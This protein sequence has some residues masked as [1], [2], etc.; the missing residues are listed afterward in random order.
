MP[1]PNDPVAILD[2]AAEKLGLVASTGPR[3]EIRRGA[4]GLVGGIG[5][6]RAESDPIGFRLVV[7]SRSAGSFVIRPAVRW[8]SHLAASR[9]RTGAVTFD[10]VLSCHGAPLTIHSITGPRERDVL[11]GI[12]MMHAFAAVSIEPA[13]LVLDTSSLDLDAETLVDLFSKLR[14]L[15]ALV[16]RTSAPVEQRLLAKV[17]D[18]GAPRARAAAAELLFD[19]LVPGS[20]RECDACLAMAT[21]EALLP[22]VRVDAMIRLRRH[23]PELVL[24]PMRMLLDS[25]APE[26]VENAIRFLGEV[27][28]DD[29]V[30]AI[31][32]HVG[33]PEGSVRRAVAW[34]LG[35]LG[36]DEAER[37]LVVLVESDDAASRAAME[38]LVFVGGFRALAALRPRVR[39]LLRAAGD[40]RVAR[41]AIAAIEARVGA[42]EPGRLAIAEAS[43]ELSVS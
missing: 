20:S 35:R 1:A 14:V 15:A 7:R 6:V 36:G 17:I 42:G 26:V 39:G 13:Q 34:T 2:V 21:C 24:T 29:V 41:A 12:H 3:V 38:A 33:H 37:A 43:G 9:V 16:A 31:T 28:A 22:R 30:P 40:K 10:G 19:R 25:H 4:A 23:D 11:L 27:G 32:R 18:D 8:Q 5:L